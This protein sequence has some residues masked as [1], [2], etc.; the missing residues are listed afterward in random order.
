MALFG[1]VYFEKKWQAFLVAFGSML[2][3]DA[4][5]GFHDTMFYVYL[6]F[7]LIVLAGFALKG[8]QSFANTTLA[9]IGCSFLFFFVTNFGSWLTDPFYAKTVSGLFQSYIRAIP[10]F[11][12]TLLGD[13]FYSGLLFGSF[14]WAQKRLPQL[15]LAAQ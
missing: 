3:S 13:L 14:S 9:V 7:G 2:L 6:S 8:K 12:N 11:R 5:L 1:G 4:F 10:F 15:Q